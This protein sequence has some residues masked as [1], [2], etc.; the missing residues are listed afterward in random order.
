M[1]HKIRASHIK[2]TPQT[3]EVVED[4]ISRAAVAALFG[5]PAVAYLRGEFVLQHEQAGVISAKLR[6]KARVTQECVLTLEP[7]E[8]LVDEE[9]VL[10]FVPAAK[11]A[12]GETE[13]LDAETLDGPDEIP[14]TGEWI[15]LS[16]A[17]AEQLALA[18][19]PYP[20]KPGA[21]LPVELLDE[22]E[23]PFAV[24]KQKKGTLF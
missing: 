16:A 24:L 12:E 3:H 7:F 19:D 14:F 6:L 11:I 17:L 23:N 1:A 4:E 9:A 8:A 13:E 20:K 22:P 5:L 21:A 18:L 10:R 2:E 15:D